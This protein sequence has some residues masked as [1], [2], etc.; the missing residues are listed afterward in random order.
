[1]SLRGSLSKIL[2]VVLLAVPAAGCIVTTSAGTY[3]CTA[4]VVNGGVL[5]L[6]CDQI[7]IVEEPST[8]VGYVCKN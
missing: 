8:C 7:K 2:V 4:S 6:H 5:V 3:D 1:M